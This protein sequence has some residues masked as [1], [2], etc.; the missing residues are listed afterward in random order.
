[1]HPHSSHHCFFTSVFSEL[2]APLAYSSLLVLTLPFTPRR[3]IT[4]SFESEKVVNE[5]KLDEKLNAVRL[6]PQHPDLILIGMQAKKDQLR[7]VDKRTMGNVLTLNYTNVLLSS[8]PFP[9]ICFYLP[10]SSHRHTFCP[11][12]SLLTNPIPY[13]PRSDYLC[14]QAL[15]FAS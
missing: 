9:S 7:V 11:F 14:Y 8:L 6:S 12:S 1:M 15:T 10:L 13:L 3:L 4:Y 2:S 5:L